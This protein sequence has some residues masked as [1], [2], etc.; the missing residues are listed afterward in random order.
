MLNKDFNFCIIK[1]NSVIS[2]YYMCIKA[3]Q[4]TFNSMRLYLIEPSILG[5]FLIMKKK[6]KI[7][8][9]TLLKFGLTKNIL[10]LKQ[11]II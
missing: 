5:I 6:L 3:L 8:R 2:K 4:S 1:F 11:I 7:V 10:P 9:N